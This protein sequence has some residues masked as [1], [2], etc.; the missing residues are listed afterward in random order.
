MVTGELHAFITNLRHRREHAGQV[1]L[2]LFAQRVKFQANGNLCSLSPFTYRRQSK[3]KGYSNGAHSAQ[4]FATTHC[5][6]RSVIHNISLLFTDRFNRRIH[7]FRKPRPV[8]K[9]TSSRA[10]YQKNP[11]LFSKLM[12][13]DL[14]R[15]K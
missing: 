14:G 6:G 5:T 2:A 9:A 7:Y 10:E 15:T 1:G 13:I 4:E 12:L 3:T 11:V 8:G